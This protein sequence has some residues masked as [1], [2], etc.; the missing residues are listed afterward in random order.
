M[1]KFILMIVPVGM[2]INSC[3]I[4]SIECLRASSNIKTKV[5]NLTG[6]TG[7]AF[8]QIGDVSI[9]QGPEYAISIQGPDNVL[10][11][12]DTEIKNND[13]I[14]SSTSC[15]NGQYNLIVNIT[16][17]DIEKVN[18]VGVGN[19]KSIGTWQCANIDLILNGS[20]AINANIEADTIRTSITG[21]GSAELSGAA[22]R[23]E[24]LNSGSAQL[25]AY[26]LSTEQ[27]SIK[28]TGQGDCYVTASDVLNVVI[29]GTGIVYYKGT[30][31]VDSKITGIG[32]VQNKN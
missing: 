16:M 7:V 10:D 27:T 32:D 12:L 3:N 18:L 20:G 2:I 22:K 26:A 15:F 14:I 9:E 25:N 8:T 4:D 21:T 23:H 17:P 30:P 1:N 29:S 24:Y 19:I 31:A 28:I 5:V 6:F 13:L 11:H